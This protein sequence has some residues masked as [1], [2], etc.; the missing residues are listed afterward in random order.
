MVEEAAGVEGEHE[1]ASKEF[2]LS[3]QQR[4]RMTMM[5]RATSLVLS[6]PSSPVVAS[7]EV[8]EVE[9]TAKTM[10]M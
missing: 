2:R 10:M 4:W 1:Q 9:Q 6:S 8:E 7:L 5:V 3:L